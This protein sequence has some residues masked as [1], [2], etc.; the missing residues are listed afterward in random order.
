MLLETRAIEFMISRG[1]DCEAYTPKKVRDGLV[2]IK[3]TNRPG[4]TRFIGQATLTIQVWAKSRGACEALC[5]KAVDELVWG[6]PAEVMDVNSCEPENGPYRWDDP[7]YKDI[8]RW[9]AT[10]SVGFNS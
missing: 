8:C 7:D 2:T 10:V 1:F 3:R 6:L 4:S 5:Q 9:Q